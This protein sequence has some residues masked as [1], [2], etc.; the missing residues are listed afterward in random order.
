MEFVSFNMRRNPRR[1]WT[2]GI[3]KREK[4]DPTFDIINCAVVLVRW[5]TRQGS[6]L[7]FSV[8]VAAESLRVS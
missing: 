1:V 7:T 8:F 2:R 6:K 4:S 5:T 3:G